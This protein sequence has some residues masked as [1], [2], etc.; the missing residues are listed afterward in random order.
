MAS[1]CKKI[2]LTEGGSGYGSLQEMMLLV[3]SRPPVQPIDD[4]AVDDVTSKHYSSDID[5]CSFIDLTVD[6][7]TNIQRG[8]VR[9]AEVIKARYIRTLQQFQRVSTLINALSAQ[10]AK[11]EERR[12][13]LMRVLET[14]SKMYR[15]MKQR[16]PTAA[17]LVAKPETTVAVVPDTLICGNTDTQ[18]TSTSSTAAADVSGVAAAVVDSVQ[19]LQQLQVEAE[20]L[21]VRRYNERTAETCRCVPLHD[22]C[23]D[24]C[25][26]DS[27]AAASD[28]GDIHSAAAA[29]DDDDDDE[30]EAEDDDDPSIDQHDLVETPPP[31]P[32]QKPVTVPAHCQYSAAVDIGRGSPMGRL[33]PAHTHKVDISAYSY[34]VG[35]Q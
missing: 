28:D 29:D 2:R 1:P 11:L 20:D 9:S 35:W 24:E 32:V 3:G 7:P 33:V 22:G 26:D 14:L 4:V 8:T 6:V 31:Q 18:V 19:Q 17:T 21:S 30:A 15:L 16:T 25:I 12:Y 27:H 23:G 13:K 10:Q 5:V 34:M